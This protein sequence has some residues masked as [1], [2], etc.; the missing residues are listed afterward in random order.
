MTS[1]Y[2]AYVLKNGH[3]LLTSWHPSTRPEQ[4]NLD[5]QAATKWL[6][7]KII[8]SSNGGEDENEGIVEFIARYK[9]NGK[10]QSLHEV[11]RFIKE[12]GLWFYVDG[13]IQQTDKP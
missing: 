1:R 8:Q 5:E 9:I 12:Q 7:L 4:I 11:S 3:Y 10:A 2:T 6:R 13:E